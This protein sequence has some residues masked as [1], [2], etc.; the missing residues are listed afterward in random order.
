MSDTTDRRD[1]RKRS[2]K[3]PSR[4]ALTI[5]DIPSPEASVEEIAEFAHSFDGYKAEKSPEACAAL[6]NRRF[7]DTLDDLRSCL[8]FEHRR[9][10]HFGEEPDAEAAA[11]FRWLVEA[12]RQRVSRNGE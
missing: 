11:Y 3:E 1:R 6:A 10:R 7:D 8:F 2:G 4:R 9:W 5:H 12:I